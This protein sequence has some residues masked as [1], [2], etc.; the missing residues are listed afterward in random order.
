[1]Q[2][3]A[4]VASAASPSGQHHSF[5]MPEMQSCIAAC[6]DCFKECEYCGEQCIGMPEMAA[7][8]KACFDCATTCQTCVTLMARESP[9]H[10]QACALCADACARCATECEKNDAEHC[11][12]CAAACRRCE[13]ECRQMATMMAA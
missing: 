9:L 4:R 10:Q 7:C 11:K 6:L 1:M 2:M 12:R 5:Q 3:G 13:Q 8:A